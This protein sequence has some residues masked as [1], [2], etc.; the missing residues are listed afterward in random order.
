MKVLAAVL[1]ALV[2]ALPAAMNLQ[3]PGRSVAI[4]IDDLPRGGD[5]GSRTQA[6]VREMTTA[7]A[8]PVSRAEDPGDRVRERRTA[9]LGRG[10]PA[11]GARPVARRRRRSR[12]PHLLA[13]RHQPGPARRLH[14]RRDPRRNRGPSGARGAQARAALLPPSVPQ[15]GTDARDQARHAGVP[16]RTRLSDRAGHDRQRR[17]PVRGGLH[18]AAVS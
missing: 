13:S 12:Q 6:A 3:G 1:L 17:L 15:D 9:G 7:A 8:G 18:A 2:V 10:R 5:G 4:T 16:R 14:R 11:A